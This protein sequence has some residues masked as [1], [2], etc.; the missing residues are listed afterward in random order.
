MAFRVIFCTF[1]ADNA[2]GGKKIVLKKKEITKKRDK[3]KKILY[4]VA[5]LAAT[6]FITTMGTSC[7]FAPD[8][9]D[10]DT[11]A[12]SE[13]YPEDT[14]AIHAK[15]KAKMAAVTMAGF[16]MGI[17]IL[18]RMPGLE[19]PSSM[20]ASSRSRGMPRIYWAIRKIKKP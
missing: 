16:T 1:A 5:A 8:Q 18:N 2:S 11:V 4:F 19:Q 17:M 10:G 14:A 7:K 13:F 6:S 15:K 12:A 3:M 9:H 20:A